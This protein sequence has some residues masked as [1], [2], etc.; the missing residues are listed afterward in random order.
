MYRD[1]IH[2]DYDD[3][4]TINGET[5]AWTAFYRGV[6]A[7]RQRCGT[8]NYYYEDASFVRLR[9]ISVA[10]DLAKVFSLKPCKSLQLVLSGRNLVTLTKYTGFDPELNGAGNNSAWDRGSD[11]GQLPN[12]KTY[13]VGLNV[14]F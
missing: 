10:I 14:G 6:Y 4:I 9:N 12:F 5:G 11:N 1:A 7:Q 13:Q 8:K 3:E 2:R